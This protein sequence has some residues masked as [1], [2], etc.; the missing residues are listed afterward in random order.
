[1]GVD[2]RV[3]IAHGSANDIAIKNAIKVAA[4]YTDHHINAHILEELESY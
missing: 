1:M 3:I 2:G 4:E